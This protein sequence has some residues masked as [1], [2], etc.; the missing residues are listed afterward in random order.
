MLMGRIK[1]R[2]INE[3]LDVTREDIVEQYKELIK[4]LELENSRILEN[5]STKNNETK[6]KLELQNNKIIKEIN[7]N[8][9]ETLECIEL[10]NNKLAENIKLSNTQVLKTIEKESNNI[11]NNIKN[12][13]SELVKEIK[14]KEK[15]ILNKV[16]LNNNNIIEEINN[17][18]DSSI[19]LNERLDNMESK[20]DAI[21][22]AI[23]ILSS[24]IEINNKKT[25]NSYKEISRK[26]AKEGIDTKES[27]KQMRLEVRDLGELTKMVLVN[28]L[29]KVIENI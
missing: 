20:L 19:K 5:I 4:K 10:Q 11:E 22:K 7:T 23:S 27:L 8:K 29:A 2:D 16:N 13:T 26:V 14:T 12:Q 17:I 21:T 9:S 15:S 3:K 24:N 1:I 18:K 6:E 25:I 28:D